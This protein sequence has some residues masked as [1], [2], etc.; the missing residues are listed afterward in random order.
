M[1]FSNPMGF[2]NNVDSTLGQSGEVAS[3]YF[4]REISN[5]PWFIAEAEL[6]SGEESEEKVMRIGKMI[7]Q[8]SQILSGDDLHED[9]LDREFFEYLCWKLYDEEYRERFLSKV[10]EF[11]GE[12]RE[13]REGFRSG[14]D[15]IY[16]I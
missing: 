3:L 5:E 9:S 16:A 12:Q 10:S 1:L 14:R 6:F 8:Y 2:L 4:F 15:I 11:V 13:Q 7:P